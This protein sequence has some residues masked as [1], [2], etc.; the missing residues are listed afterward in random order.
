MRSGLNL[1]K[2]P[3][4]K[5]IAISETIV[6][7]AISLLLG[8]LLSPDAAFFSVTGFTWLM[9]APF[10]SALRYGYT[11]AVSSA[12]GLILIMWMGAKYYP[13][14]QDISFATSAFS[15]LFIA[16]VAGEFHNYWQ[17]QIAKLTISNTTL[18]QRLTE[19][20]SAFN[21]VKISH[22]MLKH[23]TASRTSLRDSI[24]AV[25]K[26][27]I[28]AQKTNTDIKEVST[29]ILN[30]FSDYISI[31][32][33][34]LY[35][36]AESGKLNTSATASFGERFE[37]NQNDFLL[38]KAIATHKI[39]S[40]KPDLMTKDTYSNTLLLA[41]PLVD[42]YDR[43]WGIIL[44]KKMPFRAFKPAN[45]RLAAILAGHI[46]DL[47]GMRVDSQPMGDIEL[48]SFIVQVK[49]CMINVREPAI[50]SYLVAIQLTNKQ[51][52][53]NMRALVL[54]NQRSLDSSWTVNNK[55]NETIIFILLPLTDLSG[56]SDYKARI[57]QII[58]Q[59]FEFHD[60]ETAGIKFQQHNLAHITALEMLMNDLFQELEIDLPSLD[61]ED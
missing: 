37:L 61:Y 23:R 41:I 11:Y 17:R 58:R 53:I 15:I 52:A 42:V 32:Q 34:G 39:A 12:L 28:K 43:M 60:L 14:W 22:D 44:V 25:H 7:M 48:Q 18:D 31:Q 50:P 16:I 55:N 8:K 3:V 27:I 1:N 10:L 21:M 30:I 47:I 59:H 35:V 46:A 45:I 56:V 2:K 36:L 38:V 9:V 29:Y 20:T 51:H 54:G 4:K 6:L 57:E 33:A 26:R 13:P 24:L 40:L 19:V 5:R 49:R